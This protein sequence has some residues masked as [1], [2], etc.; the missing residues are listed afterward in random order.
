MKE[1]QDY[2]LWFGRYENDKLSGAENGSSVNIN[3]SFSTLQETC[4]SNQDFIIMIIFRV[5]YITHRF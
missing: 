1:S 2:H 5:K 4:I 3:V